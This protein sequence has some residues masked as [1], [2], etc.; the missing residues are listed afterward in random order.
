MKIF[1]TG[2]SFIETLVSSDNNFL[3]FD[4]EKDKW[5]YVDNI[6]DADAIALQG[7]TDSI[8]VLN[9][10]YET[11][12]S[13]GYKNQLLIFLDIFHMDEILWHWAYFNIKNFYFSKNI[14]NFVYIHTNKNFVDDKSI[15]N[16]HLF[17]RQKHYFTDFESSEGKGRVWTYIAT[18]KCYELDNLQRDLTSEHV[19]LCP[20]RIYSFKNKRNSYRKELKKYLE[21]LSQKGFL[22]D[23]SNGFILEPEEYCLLDYM[24]IKPLRGRRYMVPYS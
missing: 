16:D 4:L 24:Q 15:Y 10:Q 21:N 20:N 19:Y 14:T 12:I 2:E 8:E 17:N 5:Q 6:D 7:N 23:P 11:L 18:K 9:K 13:L 3:A 22:S 1:Y